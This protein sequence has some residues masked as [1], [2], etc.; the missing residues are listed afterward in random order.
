[1]RTQIDVRK[2][3]NNILHKLP[4]EQSNAVWSLINELVDLVVKETET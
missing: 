4:I 1:M 3:L 2:E